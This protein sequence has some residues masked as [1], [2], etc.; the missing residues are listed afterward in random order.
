MESDHF[1]CIIG[2]GKVLKNFNDSKGPKF[3][4]PGIL[5]K[6][7][8]NFFLISLLPIK[9]ILVPFKVKLASLFYN[10]SRV[11]SLSFQSIRLCPRRG[12]LKHIDECYVMKSNQNTLKTNHYHQQ[13]YATL[14]EE[15]G[16]SVNTKLT[17]TT[18]K[19]A[20]G[21]FFGGKQSRKISLKVE[22][23]G[24]VI[25]ISVENQLCVRII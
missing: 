15:E 21:F 7:L 1:K 25:T 5:Q 4:P 11:T 2:W 13:L 24:R 6:N 19:K 8:P 12:P 16:S 17:T 23:F 22:E 14:E 18:L 10:H 9:V 3:S 20:S